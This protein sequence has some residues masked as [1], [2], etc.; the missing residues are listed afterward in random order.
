MSQ[1][2]E[3]APLCRPDVLRMLA[4]FAARPSGELWQTLVRR[5]AL[6]QWPRPH[7]QHDAA[8]FANFLLEEAG[9]LHRSIFHGVWQQRVIEG[10]LRIPDFG[11]TWPL[12]LSLA[13]VSPSARRP[14]SLQTLVNQWHAQAL[15]NALS[16]VPPVLGLA[17][18]LLLQKAPPQVTARTSLIYLTSVIM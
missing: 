2:R 4:S 18:G 13:L 15:P 1:V 9:V 11:S 17:L 7:E 5:T 3:P 8:L 14:M 10:T 12:L 6:Q 16:Q